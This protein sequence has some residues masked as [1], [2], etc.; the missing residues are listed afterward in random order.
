MTSPPFWLKFRDF[1][2]DSVRL[3]VDFSST[4]QRK[5]IPPPPAEKPF[6]INAERVSLPSVASIQGLT[7]TTITEA[8]QR[9]ESHRVFRQKPLSLN[10]L[11]YL[12]WA[13]QG[14]RDVKASGTTLRTV[15]SAGSRHAFE[16]Y[17]FVFNVSDLR[18]GVYRYL[19][20]EHELLFE[21]T[22]DDLAE[23]LGNAALGQIFVGKAAVS[24]VWTVIPYRMEWRY[25]SASYKTLA[26]D[27]GHVAQNLYLACA[28]IGLGTCAV[29]AYDQKMMDAL[30]RVDGDDEFAIYMAPVGKIK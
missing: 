6:D 2:K 7:Q 4:D 27:A 30:L 17:L 24:I 23:K 21:F 14:V 15:P 5:G 18:P 10:E 12:L 29:A 19:P 22:R 28:G 3:E 11:S 26:L 16:T 25:G 1:L 20:L 8:I 9:R 13:T